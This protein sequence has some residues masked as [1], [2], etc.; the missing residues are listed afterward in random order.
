[1][2]KPNATLSYVI[3][4]NTYSGQADVNGI[5]RIITSGADLA[6]VDTFMVT[7]VDIDEFGVETA[8]LRHQIKSVVNAS[9]FINDITDDNNVSG[10]VSDIDV[11][12]Y[13][14]GEL[15]VGDNV[16]LDVEVST[17]TTTV[18]DDGT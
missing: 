12:G 6:L 10:E 1:M 4:D 16:S 13:V 11:N 2:S 7:A 17:F 3:N 18:S 14:L 5:R 15:E 8:V 9:V